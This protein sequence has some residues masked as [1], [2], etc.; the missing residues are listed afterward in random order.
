MKV[1]VTIPA[2]N[3]EKNIAGVICD[4]KRVMDDKGFSYEILIVDDGSTDRTAA[5]AKKEG[6]QVVS[7]PINLGLAD[8]F[9]TEMAECLRRKADIIVHTDADGQ[10]RAD[11]IPLLIKKFKDGNNLVLGSR[12]KGRIQSM[13]LIKRMGN[14]A[15]SKVISQIAKR[16]ISDGQTGFRVFSPEVARLPMTSNYTYTQEQIIHTAR[17]KMRIAEVP[18]HFD[19]RGKKTKSRLMKGPF[20]YA[21]KAGVNLIRVYRDY[22]P[23]RFFGLIGGAFF[24]VGVLLGIFI[25]YTLLSTGI[26][27]GIPRV[28]LTALLILTGVQIIV[29][30]FLADMWRK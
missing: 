7:H 17:A 25:L 28:V 4:I 23:L 15:F 12:F 6:A 14:I 30:G 8:T 22:E 16:P 13:P 24:L 21:M 5:I 19:R 20:D 10:Y 11:E 9:R 1:V 3:E 2:Y 27:G 29:F 26:V 18:I